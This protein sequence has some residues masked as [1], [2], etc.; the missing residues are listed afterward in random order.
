MCSDS[1]EDESSPRDKLQK[2]SK[3]LSDF[4]IKNIK[5]ADF[6]RKEIQIA[7]QGEH[8]DSSNFHKIHKIDIIYTAPF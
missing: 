1:S 2:T 7:E 6:G 4:C 8:K 3:G 5:Q